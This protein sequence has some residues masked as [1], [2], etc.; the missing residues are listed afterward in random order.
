MAKLLHQVNQNQHPKP[1]I[2]VAEAIEQWLEAA[3]L[4]QTWRERYEDLI[5]LY[6]LP[7]FGHL[8][9]AKL[10]AEL[11]E[12]F[13]ARLHRCRDLCS[14][15]AR[16]GHTCRPT[17]DQHDPQDPLHHSRRTRQRGPL[18]LPRR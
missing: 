7:T 5:R 6:V 2:T 10:D 17:L 13:Y 12:R 1:A 3:E 8:P 18:A 9:A 16:G 14:G 4:E 15:K 11:L